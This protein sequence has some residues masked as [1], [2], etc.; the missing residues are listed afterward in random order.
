MWALKKW[1]YFLHPCYFKSRCMTAAAAPVEKVNLPSHVFERGDTVIVRHLP[2]TSPKMVVKEKV[3]AET[4]GRTALDKII[5]FW[6]NSIGDY[7]VQPFDYL[8]LKV[9]ARARENKDR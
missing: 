9:V 3:M 5:A 1:L 7:C 2:E 8:D 6:F 4:H